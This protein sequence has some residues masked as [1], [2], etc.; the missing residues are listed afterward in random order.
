M[1][2]SGTRRFAY[3]PRDDENTR[4]QKQAIFVVASGCS[5]AG[6]VWTAMYWLA[7]GWTLTT[8]L[9]LLFTLIVG[10][11]LALSHRT[12]NHLY[13]VYAQILCITYITSLI[14]WS[15]GGLFASGFVLA[16]AFCGP[17][18]ALAFFSLRRSMVFLALYLVNLAVTVVFDDTFQRYGLAVSDGTRSLFFA[19]N[20]SVSSL[21]VFFF[22]SYFAG[23]ADSERVRADLLQTSLDEEKARQLGPYTL[24]EKLG[25]G[26]MGVVYKARHALLRRPTAVK[27]LPVDK[28]GAESLARFEREVQ[29]TAN[30]MHPNIVSIYDYGRSPDGVFYYAME[31]LDGID[32][33]ALVR[34]AG[35]LP[36]ARAV[37][38]LRQACEALAEAHHRGLVHRDVKPANV[39]LGRM[40]TRADVVKVLD[41]G[42]VKELGA[43]SDVTLTESI[44]GTP[45]FIAPEAVSDSAAVGPAA[46][47][48]ALGAVAYWLLTARTV[49][50]GRTVIEVCAHHL[51]TRPTPP[52]HHVGGI[53]RTLD[54]LVLACLAKNPADR[55]LSAGEVIRSLNG[56]LEASS[57]E[58]T[59]EQ[60][61]AWWDEF[62]E[63][64]N[65]RAKTAVESSNVGLTATLHARRR[66]GHATVD[67][68]A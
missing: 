21:V 53:P 52:S 37:H 67:A 63:S 59:A 13:A 29:N 14:Q 24:E 46:D 6:C 25:E 10:S 56:I 49:F 16:W 33:D 61:R 34:G 8:V 30:L 4:R 1:V 57:L 26:G 17:I 66:D 54:D 28:I 44:T 9:P 32:L 41:F 35:P 60:G 58:W 36:V 15:I 20:L 2:P 45:A 40:G 22:A 47:L 11:A 43:D 42:L 39:M 7:F 27:L 68:S 64:R 12:R 3:D 18:T 23:S 5:A 55:P 19:M 65:D 31:Y 50:S 38:I 48:Y 62:E 51:H